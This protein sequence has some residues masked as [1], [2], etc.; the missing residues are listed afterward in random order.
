MDIIEKLKN[1]K[2]NILIEAII[3]RNLCEIKRI[4][5]DEE[6]L[7]NKVDPILRVSPLMLFLEMEYPISFLDHSDFN[8]NHRDRLGRDILFYCKNEKQLDFCL[9]KIKT[10]F[11]LD[12]TNDYKIS[13]N[14]L[15]INN[16]LNERSIFV[17][18]SFQLLDVQTKR[19]SCVLDFL[20]SGD[21]YSKG[22]IYLIL[23]K[24]LDKEIFHFNLITFLEICKKY[25]LSKVEYRI[26]VESYFVQGIYQQE[27]LDFF[28]KL[29]SLLS[30]I[31]DKYSVKKFMI[32]FFNSRKDT[33]INKLLKNVL[34]DLDRLNTF[35]VP[36]K[37]TNLLNLL[38][39]LNHCI[40]KTNCQDKYKIDL[41]KREYKI[42]KSLRSIDDLEV[43]E[44]YNIKIANHSYDLLNWGSDL[45]N[46]LYERR[47]V[48]NQ[49]NTIIIALRNRKSGEIKYAIE[50]KNGII[51]NFLGYRNRKLDPKNNESDLNILKE[52]Y[53]FLYEKNLIKY[54]YIDE[55]KFKTREEVF[56]KIYKPFEYLYIGIIYILIIF[57]LFPLALLTAPISI[58]IIASFFISCFLSKKDR[59]DDI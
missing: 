56:L 15:L 17:N 40:N 27:N 58:P 43:N 22:T 53:N 30:L 8:Y 42:K 32:Q 9:S 48:Y 7:L 2:T 3:Q 24:T 39:S 33:R 10:H 26:I 13:K 35:S 38:I 47:D 49:K 37:A 4:V 51:T 21:F 59:K 57:V 5:K 41:K 14:N 44:K 45:L 55:E 6:Y 19:Y 54:K 1:Q 23:K 29:N 12:N 28:I 20:K 16:L 46:C 52:T 18:D 11:I 34:E 36:N 50:I 25:N 31:E